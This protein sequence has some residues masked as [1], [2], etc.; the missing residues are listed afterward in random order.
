MAPL[1]SGPSERKLGQWGCVPEGGLETPSSSTHC[2][3]GAMCEV[4]TYLLTFS[5]S[6]GPKQP[7]QAI[8]G[9]DLF[10]CVCVFMFTHVG[11]TCMCVYIHTYGGQRLTLPQLLSASQLAL[12]IPCPHLLSTGVTGWPLHLLGITQDLGI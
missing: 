3:P 5:S 7:G 1:K 6:T 2:S 4:N 9:C 8:M 11:D 12:D 10:V